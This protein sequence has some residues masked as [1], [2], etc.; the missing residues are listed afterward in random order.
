[1]HSFSTVILTEILIPFNVLAETMQGMCF[2]GRIKSWFAKTGN[3]P[4]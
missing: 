1:M 2:A 3:W 4:E